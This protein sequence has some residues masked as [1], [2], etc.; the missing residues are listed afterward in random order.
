MIPAQTSLL[1]PARE[2]SEG[3]V[4]EIVRVYLGGVP[5]KISFITL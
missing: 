1:M 2:L 4:N 3:K 5:L